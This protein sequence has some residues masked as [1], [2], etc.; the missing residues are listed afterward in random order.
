MTDELPPAW[1]VITIKY[2]NRKV[3]YKYFADYKTHHINIIVWH[4]VPSSEGNERVEFGGAANELEI[5]RSS[6]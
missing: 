5:K 1:L 3:P 6:P 2:K 4:Y